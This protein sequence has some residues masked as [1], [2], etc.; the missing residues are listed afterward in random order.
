MQKIYL[1]P[2]LAISVLAAC[3]NSTPATTENKTAPA[4]SVAKAEASN[5]EMTDYAFHKIIADIPA[6]TDLMTATKKAG[7]PFN[8]AL[9]NPLENTAKYDA[10]SKKAMNYGVYLVDLLYLANYKQNNELIQY[11]ATT[12]KMADGIGAA[13]NFDAV[14]GSARI[15]ANQHNVDSMNKII[16][17][18]YVSIDKYLSSSQR[19]EQASFSIIG[20][21]TESQY[22]TLQSMK[23]LKKDKNTTPLFESVLHQKVQV[24]NILTLLDKYKNNADFQPLNTQFNTLAEV[25]KP[26]T[27]VEDVTPEVTTKL[28]EEIGKIRQGIIE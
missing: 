26:L 11:L 10:S 24:S 28:T 25:Y 6:P 13:E 9:L 23:N 22:I 27:K 3:N 7:V 1:L 16:D 17:A 4:D 5:D 14:A 15:N 18:A 21:W 12:R 19:L 20:S 2:L 8:K